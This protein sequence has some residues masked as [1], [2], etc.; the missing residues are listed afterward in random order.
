MKTARWVLGLVLWFAFGVAAG[1]A[2]VSDD[3][4]LVVLAVVSLVGAAL[5]NGR[6]GGRV[7]SANES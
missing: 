4:R 6:C 2:V 7:R 5:W 1:I 3:L